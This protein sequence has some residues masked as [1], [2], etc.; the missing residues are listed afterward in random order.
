M[1]H[2]LVTL[3]LERLEDLNGEAADEAEG[4]ALE[5]VVA[6]E[7]VEVDGEELEGDYQVVA[8]DKVVLETDDVVHVLRIMLL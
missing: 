2:P 3:V 4:D 5:V 8:E 1:D 7:F 6:D